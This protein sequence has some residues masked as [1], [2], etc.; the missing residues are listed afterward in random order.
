MG[1]VNQLLI[2]LYAL[3]MCCLVAPNNVLA[4]PL[5]GEYTINVTT[6]QIDSDSYVFT[7]NVTN[8]SQSGYYTGLDGFFIQVPETAIISNMTA[9]APYFGWG[10]WIQGINNGWWPLQNGYMEL[11]WWG[12]D[13]GSVYPQ[14][15]TAIFSFQADNVSIGIIPSIT[16]TFWGGYG[17][18]SF[19][20][21]SLVGPGSYSSVPEPSTIFLLCSGLIGLAVMRRRLN[22]F[23]SH[24]R[25]HTS[26]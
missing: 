14:S 22:R 18:Y 26:C 3:A 20:S 15:T 4:V 17:N 11:F 19:Y 23:F 25:P 12:I 5:N 9:P 7:Y 21:S 2:V 13:P 16:A 1:K 24:H 8:V 6:A 10:Y